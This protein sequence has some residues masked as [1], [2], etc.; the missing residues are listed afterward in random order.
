M[1]EE[2]ELVGRT[3]ANLIGHHEDM[4]A[5]YLEAE[6]LEICGAARGVMGVAD[7]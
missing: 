3:N 4:V 1:P 7:T 2:P 6:I 5:H